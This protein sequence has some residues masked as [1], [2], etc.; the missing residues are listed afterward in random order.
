[1]INSYFAATMN[2]VGGF[3]NNFRGQFLM[4]GWGSYS[5]WNPNKTVLVFVK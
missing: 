2:L 4:G 5:R 3:S 1:M